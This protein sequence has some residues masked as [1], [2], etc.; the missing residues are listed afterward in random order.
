MEMG[1]DFCFRSGL[2]IMVVVEEVKRKRKRNM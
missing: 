2:L 1:L